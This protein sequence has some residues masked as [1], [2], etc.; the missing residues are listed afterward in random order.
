MA[1]E[2]HD[3]VGHHLTAVKLQAEA[4][5]KTAEKSPE[6]AR[7]QMERARDLAAEAFEEVRRSVRALRPPSLGEVR[8]RRAAG[9]GP[10]LRGDRFRGRLRIDG[11]ERELPEEAELV[12]YRA[13][14]EGLTNAA[15]H[16]T[17]VGS[18]LPWPTRMRGEAGGDRRRSGERPRSRGPAGSD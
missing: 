11:E 14:Q 10:Q 18:R 2:I 13:L 5:L 12:L 15:R 9:A 1:R 16:S 8:R 7:E 4:A 3:S 6:K 17:P